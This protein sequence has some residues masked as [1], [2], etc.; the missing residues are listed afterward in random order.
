MV[1]PAQLRIIRRPELLKRFGIGNTCLHNRINQGLM[2][3]PILL[4]GPSTRAVGW[5]QHELDAVIA[6]MVAAKSEAY[7]KALIEHLVAQ[8]K[9]AVQGS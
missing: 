7:I 8:R 5:L 9:L 6:A 2:P 3:P 4:G 1:Q